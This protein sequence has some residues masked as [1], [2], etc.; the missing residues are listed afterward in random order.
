MEEDVYWEGQC[1]LC[2]SLFAGRGEPDYIIVCPTCGNEME[3]EAQCTD[4]NQ[5]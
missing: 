5:D 2:E 4:E 3:W 1:T